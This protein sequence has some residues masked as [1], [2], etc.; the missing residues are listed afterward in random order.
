[1]IST[2][3][4]LEYSYTLDKNDI[5]I[6]LSENWNSFAEENYGANKCKPE[7]LINK[8]LWEFIKGEEVEFFYKTIFKSLRKNL[9]PLTI[10]HRCDSPSKRRFM[11]LELIPDISGRILL[12]S[13][14]LKVEEREPNK[15]LETE[16][17]RSNEFVSMCSMCKKIVMSEGKW[18]E[19]EEYVVSTNLF[20][21]E[22]LPKITHG[23]CPMCYEITMK[24]LK[25]LN[26][27][28]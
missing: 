25:N 6:D 18:V 23:I 19:I 11:E 12:K 27:K 2:Y 10:P 1:M 3:N 17:N 28:K 15:F 14:I 22:K 21:K 16:I 9:I 7:F 5:I 26:N 20:E 13:S 4:K 8:P 24:A